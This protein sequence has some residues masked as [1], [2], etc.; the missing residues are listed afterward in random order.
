[1]KTQ[2]VTV[3]RLQHKQLRNAMGKISFDIPNLLTGYKLIADLYSICFHIQVN[4]L[5]CNK[6]QFPINMSCQINNDVVEAD[7]SWSTAL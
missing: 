5:A 4:H 7:M 1:M 2:I 3:G 6:N